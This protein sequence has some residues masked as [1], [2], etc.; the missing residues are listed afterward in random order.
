[1]GA[2]QPL[3][4]L[5]PAHGS[6]QHC[7]STSFGKPGGASRQTNQTRHGDCQRISKMARRGMAKP[8]NHAAE[9]IQQ[10]QARGIRNRTGRPVPSEGNHIIEIAFR[11]CGH[12]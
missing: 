4:R 10:Q 11:A 2:R 5:I 12:R 8:C 1:M 3:I 7:G 6:G 9:T